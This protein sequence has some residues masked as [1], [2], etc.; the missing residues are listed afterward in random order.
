MTCLLVSLVKLFQM[1]VPRNIK[2][3]IKEPVVLM[4]SPINWRGVYLRVNNDFLY[5]VSVSRLLGDG[6]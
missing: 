1:Y 4:G 5:F 3:P 6:Y 2:E